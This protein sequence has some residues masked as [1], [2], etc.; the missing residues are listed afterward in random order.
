MN[1]SQGINEAKRWITGAPTRQELA[2]SDAVT[3]TKDVFKRAQDG[4][5]TYYDTRIADNTAKL[6]K[7]D[8][9]YVRDY[10]E[11]PRVFLLADTALDVKTS[12]DEVASKTMYLTLQAAVDGVHEPA[13]Q[14]LAKTAVKTMGPLYHEAN[15]LRKE[16]IYVDPDHKFKSGL[17]ALGAALGDA[18]VITD[19]DEKSQNVG[20][21]FLKAIKNN[22][23]NPEEVAIADRALK[24]RGENFEITEIYWSALNRIASEEY[25]TA[26][27][28]AGAALG[29]MIGLQ[30]GT[31]NIQAERNPSVTSKT[32]E[33]SKKPTEG[34][35]AVK[36]VE[37]GGNKALASDDARQEMMGIMDDLKR[38]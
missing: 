22:S 30:I 27:T 8:V 3:D 2:K 34:E 18:I 9:K 24:S 32:P 33:V 36:T 12:F 4:I 29:G 38:K 17:R 16:P 10:T 13:S 26:T 6:M 1:I 21:A 15:K 5:N 19:L 37:D 28:G 23:D 35:T 31:G 14:L 20:K 7:S 25:K 11:D